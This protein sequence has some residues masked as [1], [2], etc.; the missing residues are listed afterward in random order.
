[1]H[2]FLYRAQKES[3]AFNTHEKNTKLIIEMHLKDSRIF[4]CS[5]TFWKLTLDYSLRA[6]LLYEQNIIVAFSLYCCKNHTIAKS[7]A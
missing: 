5:V 7:V 4:F 2:A 1:M 3:L 6:W